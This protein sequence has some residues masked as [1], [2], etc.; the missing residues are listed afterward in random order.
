[1]KNKIELK[2]L[3]INSIVIVI[4]FSLIYTLLYYYEYKTYTLNYNSKINSIVAKITKDYPNVEKNE[5]IKIINAE[6]SD[7][8]TVLEEYGIDLNNDSIILK[9]DKYFN[10]YIS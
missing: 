6:D 2:K 5:L 8:L 1:M 7:D 4:D 10:K 9:N 3:L